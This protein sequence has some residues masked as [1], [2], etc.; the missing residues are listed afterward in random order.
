MKLILY[1][2]TVVS[3]FAGCRK[4]KSNELGQFKGLYHHSYSIEH[5]S[6]VVLGSEL[7]NDF[8]IK[9][10]NDKKVESYI[11]GKIYE[12]YYYIDYELQNNEHRFI[13]YRKIDRFGPPVILN[14]SEDG[15]LNINTI[16]IKSKT[17]VYY[18]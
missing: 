6:E 18:K 5:F 11:D 4:I 15:K 8:A 17:N 3:L 10:V 1:I 7:E 16:P 12:T 14:I 2:L 9:I 13:L